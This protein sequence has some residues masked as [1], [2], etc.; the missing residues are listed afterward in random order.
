MKNSSA[1]RRCAGNSAAPGGGGGRSNDCSAAEVTL[2]KGRKAVV[3]ML[4]KSIDN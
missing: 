3:R 1:L 4:G 2:N